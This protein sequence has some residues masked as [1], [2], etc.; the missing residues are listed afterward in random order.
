VQ[1]LPPNLSSLAARLW[2]YRARF[3]AEA[4]SRFQ[5]LAR[6]LADL[7]EHPALADLAQQAAD[8]ERDHR[9]RCIDAA[10]R[11]SAGDV[12]CGPSEVELSELGH[13]NLS[14]RM[15]VLHETAALCCVSET[16][17][18]ALL[19]E[20]HRRTTD[21][22]LRDTV[23]VILR[24]EVQHSRLGWA[25]LGAGIT[26]S[27]AAYLSRR[28]PSMLGEAI[29]EALFQPLPGGDPAT[30]L[31]AVGALPRKVR[32]DGFLAAVRDLVLPGFEHVGVDASAGR[33]WLESRAPSAQTG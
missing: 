26:R 7:G 31:Q 28:L 8:D 9:A 11:F 23:H 20:I 19:T 17:S 3:E 4:A 15:R 30:P 10:R 32:R 21:P 29:T 25:A 12:D 33:A 1:P 16:A 2:A 24:D 22:E 6:R 13:P 18:A 27:E 14:L 5:R